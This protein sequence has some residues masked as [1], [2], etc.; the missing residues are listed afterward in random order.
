ME[1]SPIGEFYSLRDRP[2][3]SAFLQEYR[4]YAR[5]EGVNPFVCFKNVGL[6]YCT[7]TWSKFNQ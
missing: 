7:C 6:S 4:E 3:F 2:L 5:R 1:V